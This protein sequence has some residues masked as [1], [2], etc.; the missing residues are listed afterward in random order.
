MNSQSTLVGL[1]K[2]TY[3]DSIVEAWSYMAKLANRIKFISREK[4]PGDYFNVPVDLQ[5]EAGVSV[6]AAGQ[7]PGSTSGV[8]FF[9][10][11]AGMMQNAQVA[12]AQIIGRSLVSYESIARSA[13]DKAAFK[14]STEAVVRRLSQ[15]VLKRLEIQLLHGARNVG[16]IGSLA[17]E[18]GAGP[19]VSVVTISDAT[20]SAGIWSGMVGALVDVYQSNM[21]T[22][23]QAA[24]QNNGST[25]SCYVSAIDQA[26]KTVTLTY[27]TARSGWTTGDTLFFAGGLG[28]TSST[29]MFGLDYITN[30]TSSSGTFQ[31]IATGTYDLWRGNV[32]SSS[33]GT[34]SYPKLLEAVGLTASYGLADDICAVVSPRGFEVLNSDIAALRQYDVSYTAVRAENGTSS[35]KFHG[36]TGLIEVL[37][38]AFQKDGLIHGFCPAEA[39]RVGATDVSFI[40]RQGSEDK[41][42]LESATT[43][44]SEMRCYSNQSLMLGQPR[45][46]FV[47]S[48]IT[49]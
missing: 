38:H 21:T 31:N 12:G 18:T 3:G 1:F 8:Y 6:A 10:A 39:Q 46:S 13:N 41:L 49:Y 11:S 33:T 29:E 20:W 26:N 48:G 25:Q 32:Y 30:L 42:I 5:F 9:P 24:N 34:P 27:T 37:P 44:G 22:I 35:L 47:M 43:A 2:E 45:H 40:T 4:Q 15:T 17:A 36:Q 16:A 7:I 19:Y 23:R 28:G 14:S